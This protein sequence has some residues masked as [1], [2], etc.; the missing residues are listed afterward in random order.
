MYKINLLF[1]IKALQLLPN[2]KIK[3]VLISV[4]HMTQNLCQ[5]YN[6]K[7]DYTL[8][9]IQFLLL[10]RYHLIFFF[11]KMHSLHSQLHVIAF[12]PRNLNVLLLHTMSNFNLI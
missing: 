6:A 10:L 4:L 11:I 8:C 5:R 3:S 12:F 7:L 9:Q 1:S 2:R